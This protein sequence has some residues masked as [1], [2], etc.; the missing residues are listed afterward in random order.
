MI[1]AALSARPDG[2]PEARETYSRNRA[3][4]EVEFGSGLSRVLPREDFREDEREERGRACESAGV[5][6]PKFRAV[7]CSARW[8]RD[9]DPLA[10]IRDWPESPKRPRAPCPRG[11]TTNC[12]AW[13]EIRKRR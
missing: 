4:R 5:A 7:R 6:Q 8:L 12:C 3:G 9:Q 11:S 10:A 2:L 13:R 1:H